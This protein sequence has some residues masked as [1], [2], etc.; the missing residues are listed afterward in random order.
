MAVVQAIF[1]TKMLKAIRLILNDDEKSWK[2]IY[3]F[4][5]LFTILFSFQR[6]NCVLAAYSIF[7]LLRPINSFSRLVRKATL[8]TSFRLLFELYYRSLESKYICFLMW[9][10]QHR[11]D[12]SN[13]VRFDRYEYRCVNYFWLHKRW[14]RDFLRM[15]QYFKTNASAI[16]WSPDTMKF[17]TLSLL[18]DF[19]HYFRR[20]K[21]CLD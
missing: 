17:V 16:D 6:P 20:L 10:S 12:I 3:S 8:D 2:N 5:I 7:L 14:I 11:N 21:F 4:K 15:C 9:P 18:K 1:L 13:P 19:V